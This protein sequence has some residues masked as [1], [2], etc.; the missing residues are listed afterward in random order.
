MFGDVFAC[1]PILDIWAP[2]SF[3]L[4]ENCVIAV[5]CS[6]PP[7][8][9]PRIWVAKVIKE[10]EG[11]DPDPPRHDTTSVKF[12]R[13]IF[14]LAFLPQLIWKLIFYWEWH[15]EI[16]SLEP[17]A[18]LIVL[19]FALTGTRRSKINSILRQWSKKGEMYPSTDVYLYSVSV[20]KFEGSFNRKS[21]KL[22]CF[23]C[24]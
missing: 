16:W 21:Q 2:L 15:S 4:G 18:T 24:L 9:S 17:I 19:L 1:I 14:L 23:W 13:K 11:F 3:S 22:K 12:W 5:S 6:L 7:A 8:L 20:W 10:R